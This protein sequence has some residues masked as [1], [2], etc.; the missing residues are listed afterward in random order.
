M[1]GQAAA[2]PPTRQAPPQQQQQRLQLEQQQLSL[3]Q[4]DPSVLRELPPDVQ[5][6]VMQQ[7]GGQQ[8]QQGLGGAAGRVLGAQF[9]RPQRRSRLGEAQGQRQQPWGQ[10]WQEEHQ[11]REA[12]AAAA[13]GEADAGPAISL[14]LEGGAG[15]I[16]GEELA[17]GGLEEAAPAAPVPLPPQVQQFLTQ[18]EHA[19]SARSLAAALAECLQQLE[20]QLAAGPA[21]SPH[22]LS[23]QQLDRQQEVVAPEPGAGGAGGS[24]DSLGGQHSSGS[25]SQLS[26]S[27]SGTNGEELDLP[28]TQ[29][30][31][32]DEEE[33]LQRGER[34]PAAAE[35]A[36]A[37]PDS[38]GKAPRR[39]RQS[40]RQDSMQRLAGP[41]EAAQSP[42][43]GPGSGAAGGSGRGG[44]GGRGSP[45]SSNTEFQ[46]GL[47]AVGRSIRQA[48]AEL[49][50]GQDLE[51]LRVLLRAVQR[52]GSAHPWFA[53]AAGEPAVAAAQQGVEARLGWRLRL[54]GLFDDECSVGGSGSGGSE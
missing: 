11:L 32:S 21:G 53:A 47:Q 37:P 1:H 6:E 16:V 41:G 39:M 38:N 42:C 27:S 29:K 28:P 2:P 48:A 25:S 54:A 35:R 10:R 49:L 7:L 9:G 3:S 31:E 44:R 14:L 24:R 36:P 34:S 20:A 43:K 30:V 19:S 52:L 8:Q 23:Q 50:A 45:H 4:V 22:P 40:P 13:A 12:E 33:V 15:A 5:R 26:S 46:R 18:A 51:Q 17:G